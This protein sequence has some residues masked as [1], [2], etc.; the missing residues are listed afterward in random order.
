MFYATVAAE[1]YIY[2]YIYINMLTAFP[3]KQKTKK[4]CL[5]I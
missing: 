2:I 3:E 1:I 5:L 4:T